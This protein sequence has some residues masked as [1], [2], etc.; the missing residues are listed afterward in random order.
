LKF[1]SRQYVLSVVATV[2]LFS[3]FFSSNVKAQSQVEALKTFT[4]N[5][6][7]VQQFED[8]YI[9]GIT[10]PQELSVDQK[11]AILKLL[12]FT[13][14]DIIDLPDSLKNQLLKEG[15]VKVK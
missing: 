2:L 5:N 9:K 8:G 11:D 10:A 7:S 1:L 3:S 14:E 15:G 4:L 6:V 13:D 12:N